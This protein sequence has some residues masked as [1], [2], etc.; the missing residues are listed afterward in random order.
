M[1]CTSSACPSCRR[2]FV[3]GGCYD[4][5]IRIPHSQGQ[6][7]EETRKSGNSAWMMLC[8]SRRKEAICQPKRMINEDRTAQCL[9]AQLFCGLRYKGVMLLDVRGFSMWLT[10]CEVGPRVS[11]S[12]RHSVDKMK[13]GDT[14]APTSRSAHLIEETESYKRTDIR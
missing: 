3:N 11:D 1:I 13:M 12:T 5:A 8:S 2:H 14:M 9:G 4:A 6:T 7:G 10:V